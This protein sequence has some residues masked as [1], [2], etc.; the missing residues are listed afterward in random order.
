MGNLESQINLTS[1][2]GFGLWEKTEVPVG[3]PHK[4]WENMSKPPQSGLSDFIFETSNMSCLSDVLI[5]DP[6]HPRHSQRKPQ[7]LKLC[8]LQLCLLSF[9]QCHCV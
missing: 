3:N 9:L 7:Y 1:F 4:H 8:Y 6:V 5:P 2:H